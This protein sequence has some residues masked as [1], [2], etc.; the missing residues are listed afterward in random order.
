MVE[1]T[2]WVRSSNQTEPESPF[3]GPTIAHIVRPD[4][5]PAGAKPCA[6]KLVH[7]PAAMFVVNHELS[8]DAITPPV[9]FRNCSMISACVFVVVVNRS[10]DGVYR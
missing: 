5:V 9:A 6:S 1:T 4:T 3:V 10:A 8:Y 7:V 2:R